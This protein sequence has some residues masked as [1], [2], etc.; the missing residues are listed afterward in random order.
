ME[1]PQSIATG[2]AFLAYMLG[3][4]G[5]AWWAGRFLARPKSFV[6]EYFLGSRNM[7]SWTLAIS[8][9]A[10]CISGGTFAGFPALIYTHGWIMFLWIGSYM[11]FPL[12]AMGLMGK[13]LNQLS[14]RTG[15]IT[16]PD[17]LR[18][19]FESPA[20]GLFASLSIVLFLTVNLVAQFKS[21]AIILDVLLT[22]TPGYQSQVIPLFQSA[23][24]RVDFLGLT[25]GNLSPGYIFSLL[26]FAFTVVL[27]TMYGGFR[28]V[29]WTDVLQ[30]IVM[31]VG[32]LV[33]LPTVLY[34]AGGLSHATQTL[35]AQKPRTT[36]GTIQ[37]DQAIH[38][39]SLDDDPTP[40]FIEHVL[41]N[42][43][44]P[45]ITLLATQNQDH[46]R[47]WRIELARG[48]AGRPIASAAQV[49]EFLQNHSDPRGK[50]QASLVKNVGQGPPAITPSPV[51]LIDG[52]SQ[53]YGPS[54]TSTGLPFHPLGM[55]ISFFIFWSFSGAGHPGF[56]VRLLA[57]RDSRD[58]RYSIVT[59]TI[60]FALIYIPLV[61][62][63][64]A[65]RTLIDP[66][67]LPA[68]PDSIMPTVATRLVH[69][70]LAGILIAAPYSAVM[71]TV[72]SFLLVISSSLVRDLYQRSRRASADEKVVT[73]LSYVGTGLVGLVVTLLALDPPPFLQDVVVFASSGISATFLAATLLG[74]YWPGMTRAGAWASMISGFAIVVG[75]HAPI[76]AK[77]LG[78]LS[79]GQPI[80]PLGL[81]P[82]VWACAVSLFL[83]VLVSKWTNHPADTRLAGC[84]HKVFQ[85]F[86]GPR[87]SSRSLTAS[88]F[89]S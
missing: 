74:I 38:Y 48:P 86:F 7:S 87:P 27:Y 24:E 34:Q 41:V 79:A 54:T 28:A 49:V 47:L 84:S 10:T 69:P 20:L 23:L 12:V 60:Y 76:F 32:V 39:V 52:L 22:G 82:F 5:L 78:W 31:L 37:L 17:I 46:S 71:S 83:G 53:L 44:A 6:S 45:P 77:R 15:A 64:V 29:V 9:A 56:L 19:R 1:T 72:S 55:A 89:A 73:L 36:I 81:D 16:I 21:G 80:I 26:L 43:N 88:D 51:R 4:A 11:V 2:L 66:G 14:H 85:T 18:D 42:E 57:F 30:G 61:F 33:L 67:E 58:L 8:F 35:A 25:Q 50:L 62:I 63:F 68:G 70:L 65:A 40:T 59:V 75:A 3:V 13:R